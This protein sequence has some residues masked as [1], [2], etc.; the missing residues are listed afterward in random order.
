MKL[1]LC[2]RWRMGQMVAPGLSQCYINL[3]S[4]FMRN[5]FFLLYHLHILHILYVLIFVPVYAFINSVIVSDSGLRY[6][7]LHDKKLSPQENH[8]L[9]RGMYP[10]V[11][12]SNIYSSQDVKQNE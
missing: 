1:N 6:K 7:L 10:R 3:G 8:N 11:H 12:C 4:R 5:F 9:T 2:R